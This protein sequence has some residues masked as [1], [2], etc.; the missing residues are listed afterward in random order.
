MLA[1]PFHRSI[2]LG[3]V[4]Y[5]AA[6]AAVA[7]THADN[8]WPPRKPSRKFEKQPTN[9][10]AN[11][12]VAAGGGCSDGDGGGGDGGC[13]NLLQPTSERL[14]SHLGPPLLPNSN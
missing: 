7:A 9:K 14:I 4:I 2:L 13:I 3:I 10:Q 12:D 1:A 11:N 5:F 6:V 8:K